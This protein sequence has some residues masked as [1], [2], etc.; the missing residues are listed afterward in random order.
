MGSGEGVS[1]TGIKQ[2]KGLV[3]D[4][5]PPRLPDSGHYLTSGVRPMS[6]LPRAVS[7][8]LPSNVSC[9]FTGYIHEDSDTSGWQPPTWMPCRA[10][11]FSGRCRP[12][13]EDLTLP[14][15]PSA[16]G[17]GSQWINAQTSCPS[18]GHDGRHSTCCPLH[19]QYGTLIWIVLPPCH[20]VLALSCL[21]PN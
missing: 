5:S 9:S 16:D 20:S 18:G 11:T 12:K 14:G 15:Q 17:E 7:P 6:P 19:P 3:L 8:E 4:S 10:K 13:S 21:L 1:G 2:G